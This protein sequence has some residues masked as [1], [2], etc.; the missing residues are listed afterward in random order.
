MEITSNEQLIKSTSPNKLFTVILFNHQIIVPDM[1][2][3]E[4]KRNKTDDTNFRY[5]NSNNP[6]KITRREISAITEVSIDT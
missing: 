2:N 6:C 4:I 3:T 1:P 5:E